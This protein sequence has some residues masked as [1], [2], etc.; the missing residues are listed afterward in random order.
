MRGAADKDR[1]QVFDVTKLSPCTFDSPETLNTSRKDLGLIAST[2]K[3]VARDSIQIDEVSS[4]QVRQTGV[5]PI[6]LMCGGTC[7]MCT[8]I[9]KFSF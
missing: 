7:K 1:G 5:H 2:G 8:E 9:N 6:Y 4:S 3:P